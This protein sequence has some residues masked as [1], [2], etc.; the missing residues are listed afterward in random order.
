[1]QAEAAV[2]RTEIDG[3]PVFW[4]ATGS[5]PAAALIFRVG[6]ADETLATSGVT[7]LTEHLAL[8]PLGLDTRQH[9]N[10]QVDSVTTTFIVRGGPE[11]I[12]GF[13]HAVCASLHDLPV[14]RLEAEKRILRAEEAARGG[15]QVMLLTRR[16]GAATYGLAGLPEY[17]L[18][19]H[20]ASSVAEWARTWFTR[21]NAALWLSC[22]PPDGLRLDLPDGPAM[23][24]PAPTSALPELPA[25]F[26]A[27]A[28]GVACGTVV[29]RS[30]AATVY[31]A[32]LADRLRRELRHRQALSYSPSVSY[33]ARD[34]QAAYLVASADGLEESNTLLVSSF[35]IEFERLGTALVPAEDVHSAAR[36]M[37]DSRATAAGTLR[38]LN[39]SA[40][41]VLMGREPRSTAEWQAELLAVTPEDVR[42]AAREALSAALFM[43]PPGTSLFRSRYVPA[44]PG[45]AG[46]VAGR[47]IRSADH[48]FDQARLVIGADGASLV[49]GDRVVTVT[50]ADCA[51]LLEWPDGGRELVGTDGVSV[52][53]EPA[54]WRL[55]R[56]DL[57]RL[58]ASVPAA[59]RI[60]MP[61][62]DAGQL[63]RPRI[64]RPLR[65]LA[66]VLMGPGPAALVGLALVTAVLVTV[67]TVDH[68]LARGS[69]EF[70]V[71][72][73]LAGGIAGRWTW[74]RLA[75]AW[76]RRPR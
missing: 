4:A 33:T 59:R 21:G 16:Y 20:T 17:G 26:H 66:T 60:S 73:M 55:R 68:R 23:P 28:G 72:A 39:M 56:G 42:Q 5:E 69:T 62:R 32:V 40:R 9:H 6:R 13:L 53:V 50:G 71:P 58:G 70:V 74:F 37:A 31:R 61:W 45:P 41:N 46:L 65:W 36:A 24:P 3:I 51:A 47:R 64:R 18:G 76:H 67:I 49:L 75:A 2:T 27:P 7:H 57:A 1:M 43:L 30:A 25:Y 19:G 15:A 54:L 34:R 11:K 35:T 44:V 8:Y 38:Q 29:A 22:P 63:P 10:G 48:P 14:A 12:T 52:R